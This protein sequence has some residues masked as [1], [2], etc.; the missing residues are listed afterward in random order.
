MRL[1]LPFKPSRMTRG[2][3]FE[4]RQYPRTAFDGLIDP[5]LNVDWFVMRGP[6]FPAHPHAGFSAVTYLFA[7]SENGFDNCDSL[8]ER[9]TILPGGLHW[10]RASR[11]LMHE[12]TPL[13][14]GKPVSGLQIFMNLPADRQADVPAAFPLTADEVVQTHGEG[15][16]RRVAVNGVSIGTA[17]EAL[18]APL[19]IA[20]LSLAANYTHDEAIPAG[21][22]GLLIVLE[23]AAVVDESQLLST[24]EAIGFASE[25]NEALALQAGS[26]GARLAI[27]AGRQLNQPIHA[28]GPLML[29]SEAQ[30]DEAQRRVAAL[31]I[32][33]T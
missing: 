11:G 16:H 14:G 1:T 32:P 12:E 9:H 26:S 23:G 27:I 18:P 19:R 3:V 29:A 25:V 6:T 30:L 5:V 28:R 21:W 7:G 22:G 20:E 10:S 8:G 31:T 4:A 2:S 24:T 33:R 17:L 13:P 15:W